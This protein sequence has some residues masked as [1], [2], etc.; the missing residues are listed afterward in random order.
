MNQ[1]Y[2]KWLQDYKDA[3]YLNQSNLD[4]KILLFGQVIHKINTY[5]KGFESTIQR[6]DVKLA[7][8]MKF[9]KSTNFMITLIQGSSFESTF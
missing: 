3:T 2:K 9:N 5:K 7:L 8:Q 1:Y 4:V 6:K